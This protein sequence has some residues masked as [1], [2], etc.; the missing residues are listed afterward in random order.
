MEEARVDVVVNRLARR[1]AE[2]GRG[3]L[4]D[5]LVSAAN[6][7][8]GV[9]VH[10][11]RSLEDLEAVAR[12]VAA[13]RPDRVVLAGGDGSY[14]AGVTALARAYGDAELPALALAPGGTVSTVARNWGMRGDART[15]AAA[16]VAAALQ[17]DARVAM[18]PTLHVT[19]AAG[20]DRTGFIFGAGLVAS[21]FDVYYASPHQGYGGA[22]RIVARV[23]AESFVGG[24]YARRVLDPVAA[25]LD[26]DGERAAPDAWSLVVASVVPDLGIGMRVT[27]RA[28]E[29]LDAFHLVASALSPRALGPQMPRVLAGRRLRGAGHVDALA[30]DASLSFTSERS[31]Y[32]LDGERIA[33]PAVR[34]RPGRPLRIVAT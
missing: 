1:L 26:V 5:A 31:V 2:D 11:T 3:S 20:G 24:S 17:P 25:R 14:M 27:Y 4:R 15:A 7:R 21:F 28:G 22:A 30:K 12:D 18:R 16:V 34:V 32:V 6:G 29:R 13:R 9:R 8:A 33:A 23:F 19:D 10:E